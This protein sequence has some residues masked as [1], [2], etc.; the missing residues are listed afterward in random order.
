MDEVSGARRILVVDDEATVL[1]VMAEILRRVGYSVVE[2]AGG[3]AAIE[4]LADKSID[5]LVSDVWMPDVSGLDVLAA[6]RRVRPE[7]PAILTTGAATSPERAEA[8]GLGAVILDKPFTF[9]QLERCV[10]GALSL[11]S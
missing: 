9:A 4:A 2:A 8:E 10:A 6:A 11:R 3:A 7:L 5:L 1:A